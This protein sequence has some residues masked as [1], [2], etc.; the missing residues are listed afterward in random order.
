M[1]WTMRMMTTTR[2]ETTRTMKSTAR[3]LVV[4]T[5]SLTSDCCPFSCDLP[6]QLT[7]ASSDA[8][9]GVTYKLVLESVRV[10]I[11]VVS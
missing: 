2:A 11:G 3:R 1:T 6:F 10:V 7:V 9:A 8:S 4:A 5:T